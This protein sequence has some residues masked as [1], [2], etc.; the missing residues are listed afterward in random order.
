MLHQSILLTL[1]LSAPTDI[2]ALEF[3]DQCDSV[4]VTVSDTDAVLVAFDDTGAAIGSLA[5]WVDD[6]G[7]TWI[8]ADYADGYAVL[9]IDPFTETVTREG[10]LPAEVLAE[11]AELMLA[12]VDDSAE[13]QAKKGKDKSQHS[14][15]KCAFNVAVGTGFCAAAKIGC[16][17]WG[18]KAACA[19]VPKVVKEFDPYKCPVIG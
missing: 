19:C 13:P 10:D 11:R 16:V 18:V 7:T 6:A 5:L 12:Y 2:A 17:W 14:W 4:T 15:G 3:T 1:L 8:A 9:S